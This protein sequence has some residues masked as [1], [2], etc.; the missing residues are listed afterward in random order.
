MAVIAAAVCLAIAELCN[1][2]DAKTTSKIPTNIPAQGLDPALKAFAQSRGLQVLYVAGLVKDL[3]TAGASGEL[4]ADETLTRLLSGTGLTYRYVND[5]AITI[6]SATPTKSTSSSPSEKVAPQDRSES[7]QKQNDGAGQP[8]SSGDRNDSALSRDVIQLATLVV[9][10]SRLAESNVS[11]VQVITAEDLAREGITSMSDALKSLSASNGIL[12]GNALNG[13]QVLNANAGASGAN[14][15]GLGVGATL[16]LLNGRRLVTYGYAAGGTSSFVDL[17]SLPFGAIERIE[18]LKDGASAIYGSDAIAGVVNVIL[19]PEF[20]GL[21]LNGDLGIS[22]RGDAGRQRVSGTWGFGSFEKDGYN[23]LFSADYT[24]SDELGFADRSQTKTAD[25]TRFGLPDFRLKSSPYVDIYDNFGSAANFLGTLFPCPAAQT[26]PDGV[27]FFDQ[28]KV[29]PALPPQTNLSIFGTGSFA[30]GA[31][32]TLYSELGYSRN[33]TS[34]TLPQSNIDLILPSQTFF[35]GQIPVTFVFPGSDTNQF[36]IGQYL[37]EEFGE[38]ILETESKNL[39]AVFGARGEFG[40]FNWDAAGIWNR[41]DATQAG[42]NFIRSIALDNAIPGF[43]TP[44]YELQPGKAPTDAERTLFAPPFKNRSV[45]NLTGIQFSVTGPIFTLPAG[46][47]KLAAGGEWRREKINLI[48]DPLVAEGDYLDVEIIQDVTDSRDV[49]SAYMELGAPLLSNLTL[50]LAGRYDGYSK[51]KEATRDPGGS[52]SMKVGL[53]YEPLDWL[54]LHAINEQGFRAPSLFETSLKSAGTVLIGNYD[55]VR[56]PVTGSLGDCGAVN[57]VY[58]SNPDLKSETSNSTTLGLV[59]RPTDALQL[60][61]DGFRIERKNEIASPDL[62][63][64]YGNES[65][66]PDR[67]VRGPPDIP[68]LPGPVTFLDIRYLNIG[69]TIV[70]GFDMDA[71]YHHQIDGLGVVRGSFDT[72]YIDQYKEIASNVEPAVSVAGFLRHPRLRSTGSL[73]LDHGDLSTTFSVQYTGGY[74]EAGNNQSPCEWATTAPSACTTDS[75]TTVNWT[76]SYRIN[77][78]LTVAFTILNLFD[79]KPPF[80]FSFGSIVN[81]GLHDI[82][83]RY[84]SVQASGT[85]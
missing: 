26:R 38:R 80:D 69:R 61:L 28:N 33:K 8:P 79:K 74:R 75:F 43:S 84:F 65:T 41:G 50:Q 51:A 34:F 19:K 5:K 1:A 16:V 62:A 49:R 58:G 53:R 2:Q 23:F 37:P 4:T 55:P 29:M 21:K 24:H 9:T 68:G 45:S 66:F 78:N 15:R 11:V 22:S 52:A 73:G 27:C 71:T 76:G 47:V 72:S 56:C 31:H 3:K 40:E 18:V 82:R 20:E 7:P 44:I 14:L 12:N 70:R 42:K 57:G 64:L 35:S 59:L 13:A 83:G 6:L 25:L 81:P 54:S 10:G 36:G 17:N 77:Q 63:F 48:T 60:T 39:R 67:I 85:F 30:L 32:T 46:D